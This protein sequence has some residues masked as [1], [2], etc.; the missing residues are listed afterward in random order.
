MFNCYE[1]TFDG[2][3]SAMYGLMVYDIGGRGQSDVSFGNKA[4]I[5]ETRTNNRIQP[6]YFG[7]NYH[8]KPL[9]FKLVFGAE[10]ELDRYELEDI[11]YWL[12]GRKEYKWLSIGQQDMEQLQFR[13]MVTEL[14]PISHGWL[15]VA[16]QATIQCDCPYAYSYPFE[17]QY[18]I[19]GETTILFRN[20][21]SVREYLKPEISF[22]PASSTSALSLVNLDDDNREFKLT[23]IPSGASVFVNNSN[24][25]IQE[26]S[27][28]Y[29]LYD[30]FN[31]NFF[32]LVHGRYYSLE[33]TWA[34]EM[35]ERYY[36]VDLRSIS[37]A[38]IIDLVRRWQE[39]VIRL[40]EMLYED[41]RKE[42]SLTSMIGFGVDGS[43]KEKQQDFEGVRG[44][45][46]NNPFVTAVQEHIV[47][48]RAL[49][50]ELIERLKPLV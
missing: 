39:C 9:E 46:V 27:S 33:W 28:G 42:F 49:G 14:T 5:V 7:T 3:S 50:D 34:Y 25:I 6:I 37:A 31:L 2:E 4:S 10:R 36:G 20:E 48:K 18:T 30:G 38:E 22:A 45:F 44:D 40:D 23:G 19:S 11:A 32:R 8:S 43:N 41:A 13:C 29:N 17:K 35:I 15:P 47:N 21:S 26:L 1:F 16:F 24:G 12:T